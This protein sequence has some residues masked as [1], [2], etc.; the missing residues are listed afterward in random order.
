MIHKKILIAG[1]LEQTR[2][3][4][5]AFSLLGADTSVLCGTGRELPLLL[6][7]GRLPDPADFDGLVLPGGGDIS[8]F[9]YHMENTGARN[10]D[11]LLDS[12]QFSLFQA[13]MAA[14]KPVLGICKGLQL[15]NVAFGGTLIQEL[16]PESLAIHAWEDADKI[17]ITKAAHGT[18]PA[19]LYGSFPRVNSAHHQAVGVFGEGLRAAQYG[20]DFV[21]EAL[22]HER[23]PVLGVQWHPE[24]MCFSHAREDVEDGSK[25]LKYYLRMLR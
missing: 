12:V 17:H 25:L 15:I 4:C 2:N 1:F 14:G 3:Y 18:F 24:R 23:L 20:P 8:P 13:Y 6:A 7:D 19:Q 5:A 10:I 16:G 22:Y 9:F 11:S 21:V